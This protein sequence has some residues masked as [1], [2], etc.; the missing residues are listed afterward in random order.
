MRDADTVSKKGFFQNDR[1]LVCSML[2]FYG[3]CFLGLMGALFWGVNRQNQIASANATATGAVIATQQAYATATAVARISLQ[4]EYEFIERFDE[5]SA[6]WWVGDDK[7]YGDTTY[8]ITDGVYVWDVHKSED[9]IFE[10]NFF[11]GNKIKDFDVYLDI[12]FV[13][14][15]SRDS[16]CSGLVYRKP[17]EEWD[18]GAYVFKICRDSQFLVQYY[19]KNGWKSIVESSITDVIYPED[20]NRIEIEARGNRFVF[21]IN[22]VQVFE[23]M[24]SRLKQGSLA[25]YLEVPDE[26]SAEVWFDNFGFQSR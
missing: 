4:D 2:V 21:T 25:I 26:E 9:Y 15:E 20:W 6:R 8:S 16:V 17:Y 12:L 19:D 24:D 22:H 13:E 18:Q 10:Q 11:K 3:I 14:S 7:Y 5:T 23:T 1:M